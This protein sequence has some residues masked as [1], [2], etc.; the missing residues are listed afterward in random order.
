MEFSNCS[1]GKTINDLP[2]EILQKIFELTTRYLFCS[3]A[4][5]CNYWNKLVKDPIMWNKRILVIDDTIDIINAIEFLV[6][7][8]LLQNVIIDCKMEFI[9]LI[10]DIVIKRSRNL[11]SLTVRKKS[12]TNQ[13]YM[14]KLVEV[15]PNLSA[16][17]FAQ[18]DLESRSF[19]FI[20]KFKRLKRL[21][22]PCSSNLTSYSFKRIVNSCDLEELDISVSINLTGKIFCI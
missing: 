10:L 6:Q 13:V 14:L 9:N 16:L 11:R 22:I 12:F 21:K 18:C 19:D 5:V 20:F 2:A 4:E 17:S 7:P 15:C 3:V 1:K 8:S